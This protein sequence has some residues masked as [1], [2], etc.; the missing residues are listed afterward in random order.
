[1]ST[2][3]RRL[4]AS[5]LFV[6]AS[7]AAAEPA[8]RLDARGDPLPP[9]AFARLGTTRFRDGGFIASA[10]LSPD[11]KLFA[12][13]GQRDHLRLLDAV[14]GKEVRQIKVT[15]AGVS[16]LTFSPDGKRLA[17]ADHR[18]QVQLYDVASGA[19]AGQFT[20]GPQARLSAFV[21]SADGR[22]A[23]AG[24]EGFGQKM[25]IPVW[26]VATGKQLA[27]LDGLHNYN[28]RLALSPDGKVL[29][30]GGTFMPRTNEDRDKQAE[31][32]QTVQLW[33]VTTGK[34]LRRL[35]NEQPG[36]TG[37]A[38]TPDG[39]A[40]VVCT[41]ASTFVVW[42]VA[43]GK[44]LR[45]FAGR[46]NVGA[47]MQ[48]S[49]DGKTLAAS[50]PD[51]V[52]QAWDFATGRRRGLF[53]GPRGR[54]GRVGFTSDGRIL[55]YGSNG[56]ALQVWDVLAEKRL[57]P[58]GGHEAGVTGLAFAADGRGLVSVAAD[59]VVLTWDAAGKETRRLALRDDEML[60]YGFA[61]GRSGHATLSP[62][63]RFVLSADPMQGGLRLFE[64]AKGR[65]LC[66]FG[67]SI[68]AYTPGGAS[69]AFSPD[70]RLL[71]TA[72]TDP[73]AAGRT[74]MVRVYDVETG[75][76]VRAL[77]GPPAQSVNVA[78]A[79]DGKTFAAAS[80]TFQGSVAAETRVWDAATGKELWQG[81][82]PQTQAQGLAFTPDGKVLATRDT[83]GAVVL[84]DA[85]TGLEL[86]Q[87]AVPAG[88]LGAAALVFAP[89][90]RTFAAATTKDN[91]RGVVGVWEVATG[92][93]RHEFAGHAGL[94]STAAFSPDGTTLATGGSDTTV[95]LWD[96]TG[97]AGAHGPPRGKPAAEELDALW[98]TLEAGEAAKA[99]P[100]MRRLLEAPA[101]AVALLAKHVRP[102]GGK[103]NDPAA[104]A[105]LIAA[106][107]DD[108]FDA[109]EKATRELEKVGKAAAEALR[110]A[111]ADRPSAEMKQRLTVLLEK[112]RPGETAPDLVRA[113]R[114]V[115]VL[116]HLGTPEARQ[117][118]GALAKGQAEA[119]L[120]LA[121]AGA[122]GR[123]EKA[124][125]R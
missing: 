41:A 7:W 65:E 8:P 78:F 121:A 89:D 17:L 123:L 116:E 18:N 59:G 3:P 67:G 80:N 77:P 91:L 71:L 4:A 46:R 55:A 49:P 104:I 1:M 83:G 60:R 109:R 48:F 108:A 120:T 30:S 117:A 119:P 13:A 110:K 107:D 113:L 20:G 114:A 84:H 118:L 87:V 111:L 25:P 74:S 44:E 12:I 100:A 47:T 73:R 28:V 54:L 27:A 52:V 45:R 2:L 34:E 37:A 19:P 62:D 11:G 95:L 94:V 88:N 69:S 122:L 5:F 82:R 51:G 6:F 36:H 38:F 125:R 31:Y 63:G 98:A 115:E 68:M 26:E 76:E 39:K 79:P 93:L 81:S 24:P 103:D 106:L 124:P 16:F 40:L 75:Q 9:G 58:E 35:R 105:R 66:T 21:F 97:R 57:T 72:G 10:A 22:V 99:F 50:S 43:T 70:A 32:S 29:A 92:T 23:A 86:R 42:D 96:L 61:S 14:T 90:G 101:E 15:N 64:L 56:V 33:D 102:A 112:L 85:L 53:E